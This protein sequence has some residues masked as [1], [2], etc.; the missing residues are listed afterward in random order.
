MLEESSSLV[1]SF[2]HVVVRAVALE[3]GLHRFPE[4]HH[5]DHQRLANLCKEFGSDF[6]TTAGGRTHLARNLKFPA[7]QLSTQ[8]NL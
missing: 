3:Y 7:G 5:Q 2:T 8:A 1:L 6:T 4:L